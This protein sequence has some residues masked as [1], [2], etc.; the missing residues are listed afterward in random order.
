MGTSRSASS[1]PRRVLIVVTEQKTAKALGLG[2]LD[3]DTFLG[4]G[5]GLRDRGTTVY[6]LCR[7]MRYR[8]PGYYVSLVAEARG[9]DV[10]PTVATMSLLG[11]EDTLFEQLEEAGL[12]AIPPSRMTARRRAFKGKGAGTWIIEDE[13]GALRAAKAAESRTVDFVLGTTER[14]EDRRMAAALYRVAPV[15]LLRV[16]L[17]LEQD[18]WCPVAVTSLGMDQLD[19]AGRERLTAL[20]SAPPTPPPAPVER[21]LSLG[22]VYEEGA[23]FAP[24]TNET[25]E[26]I[27]RVGA[28]MGMHVGRIR[29]DEPQRVA[30]FDAIFLRVLTG[31]LLPSYRMALRAEALGLPVIDDPQSIFRCSNKVFLHELMQRESIPTPPTELAA[32]ATSFT[33]LEAALGLPFVVKVPD[34]SF[35]TGVHKI[36]NEVDYRTRT[37]G[38]FAKSPLLVVQGWMPTPYDWRVT[39]LGG[40][41]L[42]VARYHM[43]E[44][45]WQIRAEGR[46]GARFGRVEAIPRRTAPR[47]VTRL[48]LKA[49]ALIGDGLY[50]VDIKPGPDGPVVIEVNDNPNLDI[51]Y[52]DAADGNAIYEDLID[53]FRERIQRDRKPARPAPDKDARARA[54]DPL[55]RPIGP[56]VRRRI[57]DDYRPFE[58]CGLELEYPIVDRDLNAVSLVEPALSVLAGHPVS[59]VDLGAVGYS[60]EIFDHVLEV[61]TTLP[62]RSLAD[63]ERWLEEGVRRLSTLL[64]Q[65]F[66]ARL[67]PTGMHPWLKPEHARLWTRSGQAIYGTYQR[68]FDIQT[69]GWANVQAVHVNLPLGTE[70]EAVAMM[71]AAALLVPYLT[72]FAAS[73]PIH[74]GEIQ[75]FAD[76]RMRHVLEHQQRLPAS[77]GVIVPEYMTSYAQY[78]RDV[79]KPMYEAV[80]ALP[81]AAA[82]RHEFLNA[83]GAVIK[84]SRNSMEVRVLDVQECVKMDVAIAAFTRAAL[85]GLTTALLTGRLELPGHGLLVEDLR[86][87][88]RDGT[89]AEVHAPHLRPGREA[90]GRVPVREVMGQLLALARKHVRK[91]EA[92]YL[93]LLEPVIERGNLS[94]RIAQALTPW[95]DDDEA[96]MD[97]A[98]RL[99]VELSECLRE[100]TPWRGR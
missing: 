54:R 46:S 12:Y 41:I 44:G 16:T 82:I 80:D 14:K 74:D 59:N 9:Q 21:P 18:T 29:L 53:H 49:A 48:A 37:A 47:D 39:V 63:A 91:D 75:P 43:A 64:H 77:C 65:R 73:S 5:D 76:S 2:A 10:L 62:P 67:L 45:H 97:A 33:D 7:S 27:E 30:T 36:T 35:S 88:V 69:H 52:D 1:T 28:R 78:K 70:P 84:F 58:V 32:P 20:L 81:D 22:I 99:Y 31:P 42:F 40:K 68:L 95:T 51:G 8:S 100:N 89:R 24:S 85:K 92:A 83:R 17:L 90:E 15:P 87:T 71:N 13:G 61:K 11:D 93:D 86:A 60:N 66:G 19:A 57:R 79:F 26:R 55:R 25:I 94:E 98:R 72:A 4:T 38:L 56:A 50:G 3:A 34:G 23:P 6:N 96:F